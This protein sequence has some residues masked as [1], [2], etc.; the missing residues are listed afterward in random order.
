MKAAI[1]RQQGETPRYADVPEPVVQNNGQ[2][3]ISVKAAAIKHIDKS[4]ASGKHYSAD[5]ER[6]QATII[7]GDGVG[8]LKN[9][10]RVYAIGETG[11]AAEKA[12][13]DKDRMVKLPKNLD[14][15]TAAALPNAV[16][17]SAMGLRFRAGMKK[18]ET[19]FINGATGFTGKI[20]VQVAKI[21]GAK[22]VIV[23]GR[24]EASLQ[25]LPALGADEI[26][27]ITLEE[28]RFVAQIKEI[29][30][31]TPIDIVIDYL[32]G[33]S[34]E[35]VLSALKGNGLFTHKT[36]FVSIGA[37][38]GDI[39][40]LSAE[41]LRSVNLQLNGSGLGSWTRNEVKQLFQE[42]LPEMFELAARN[43]L[44][45]DTTSI[46]L[47]DLAGLWDSDPPA[48]KRIVATI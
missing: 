29:H 19:V 42:I 45:V 15:V 26:L 4:R 16:I 11:M 47:K 17:G 10:T 24:N 43:K 28:Q 12:V 22:K 31:Q 38:T 6:T 2:V 32:W 36:R 48:G 30:R 18:A 37:V 35:L 3:L 1:I 34:A 8:V 25:S 9:G 21:Y 39:I 13:I 27:S 33:R 23:T 20:A 44:K 46:G 41:N 40:Q 7:G 5:T 14:D